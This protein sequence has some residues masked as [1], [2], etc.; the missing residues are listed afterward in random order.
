M[1]TCKKFA[2]N[3]SRI[4]FF[5]KKPDS[6]KRQYTFYIRDK[7][8]NQTEKNYDR[9]RMKDKNP[10]KSDRN[11]F[12]KDNKDNNLQKSDRNDSS[13]D[14]CQIFEDFCF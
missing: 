8:F 1:K 3:I 6:R 5:N 10:Q 14:Y 7:N 12:Y 9:D 11:D 2:R 13:K 4:T